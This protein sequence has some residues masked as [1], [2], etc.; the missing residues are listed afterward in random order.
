MTKSTSPT[1]SRDT[2]QSLRDAVSAHPSVTG[3]TFDNATM[4]AEFKTSETF[5]TD[6]QNVEAVVIPDPDGSRVAISGIEKRQALGRRDWARI[7][8]VAAELVADLEARLSEIPRIDDP[9]PAN[10]PTG[11][12]TASSAVSDEI[13]KF[14]L[15]RD[16]GLISAHEFD[17][18]KRQLLTEGLNHRPLPA[19]PRRGPQRPA[20][21]RKAVRSPR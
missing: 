18:Q 11:A 2:W 21:D 12:L 9:A 8:K 4:R 3:A 10:Q 19:D 20:R 1:H 17:E 7:R 15:L 6:G 14:A 16:R 5:A 13:A